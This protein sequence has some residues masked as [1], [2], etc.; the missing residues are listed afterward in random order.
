MNTMVKTD[1]AALETG[2]HRPH[3]CGRRRGGTGGG[4]RRRPRQEG[5]RLRSPQGPRR[6]DA[7]G[8]PGDGAGAQRPQGPRHAGDRRPPR[9][10]QGGRARDAARGRAGRR[11]AAAPSLAARDRPHPPGLPGHRRDHRDLRRHGLQG[12][13]GA[14]HRD[15]LLQFHR[16]QLPRRPSGAGDAR[17]VLLQPAAGRRADAP[18]H[19]HLAGADPD[20]GDARSRRSASSSPAAP[21]AWTRTRPTRRCS[22]RSR[23]W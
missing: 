1:I 23:G 13:R 20:D 7:G 18:P 19:P 11:D 14:G 15:R 4:A 2:P 8:A 10:A 9:R 5:R 22:I 3:R 6:D 16:A 17:H 21:T 12:R